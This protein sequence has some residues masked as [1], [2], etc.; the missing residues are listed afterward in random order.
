[1]EQLLLSHVSLS[2]L[3]PSPHGP[4]ASFSAAIASITG[5]ASTS[6]LARPGDWCV[7]WMIGA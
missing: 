3:V 1:V 2:N 6:L 7:R 4:V 5:S